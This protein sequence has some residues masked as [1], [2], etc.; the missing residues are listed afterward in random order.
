[1]DCRTYAGSTGFYENEVL[2][3][4]SKALLG[5]LE[6]GAVCCEIPMEELVKL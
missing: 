2:T 5:Q 1:M 3:G 6:S 4:K